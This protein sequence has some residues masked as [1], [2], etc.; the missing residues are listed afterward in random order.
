MN[1]FLKNIILCL[2]TTH[3][4]H[5]CVRIAS[6]SVPKF[7]TLFPQTTV[8]YCVQNFT[9]NYHPFPLYQDQADEFFPAQKTFNDVFIL[10]IPD[11][12]LYCD[13]AGYFYVNYYFLQET[14]IKDRTLSDVQSAQNVAI[15]RNYTPVDGKIAIIGHPYPFCY[16]HWLFDILSQ[17]ALL[18]MNHVNYDFLIIPFKNGFVKD[19]LILWG[20]DP[21][22][23][24]P[25]R[26][27]I[28]IRAKTLIIPTVISQT[29]D[30]SQKCANYFMHQFLKYTHDKLVPLAKT[31]N[32]N[33][34]SEK[35]FIS[36]KDANGKRVIPNE[37]EIFQL[38][39]PFGFERY[40]LTK[41]PFI[42][43]IA[44]FNNAKIIVSFAGSGGAN[45]MFCKPDTHYIEMTH[46]MVDA[47]FFFVSQ[48]FNIEYHSIN[49]ST[50]QNLASS[51]P[52]ADAAEF[53]IAPIEQ[54]IV[55]NFAMLS[56]QI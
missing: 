50:I 12:M 34:L 20:I 37:D 38:F 7:A 29:T 5:A 55:D 16:G 56:A 10:S 33:A 39:K 45:C 17:L 42:E 40:E 46:T 13:K 41:I 35:I 53:P 23:I 43:Q 24:I 44:L 4:I 36:R 21:S 26:Q 22:K 25:F 28:H 52:F 8:Q 18:E 51:N 14:Q 9:Q 15:S 1:F 49:A 2:L 11:A 27:G 47:T 3:C 6:I 30:C 48:L 31:K 19:S 54:F 32:R